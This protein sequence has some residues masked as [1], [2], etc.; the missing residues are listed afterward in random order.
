MCWPGSQQSPMNARNCSHGTAITGSWRP[1]TSRASAAVSSIVTVLLLRLRGQLHYLPRHRFLAAR[2]PACVASDV[3]RY[4]VMV[5]ARRAGDL[6]PVDA[7]VPV[8]RG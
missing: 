8:G 5:R 6:V 1:S 7:D 4:R 2:L 3:A